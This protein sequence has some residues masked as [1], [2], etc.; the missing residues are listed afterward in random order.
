MW[1]KLEHPDLRLMMGEIVPLQLEL[2]RAK[3]W[4]VPVAFDTKEF[5][6]A[7]YCGVDPGQ[8]NS[9]L[10][11][12]TPLSGT[13]S[14]YQIECASS[15]DGVERIDQTVSVLRI[16]LQLSASPEY[17]VVEAAAHNALYGQSNLAEARTAAVAALMIERV[18]HI[19]LLPPKSVRK[20]AFGNGDQ[21]AE[22]LWPKLP[23]D[24]ASALACA[25]AARS[26]SKNEQ[27]TTA[28]SNHDAD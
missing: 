19:S 2:S 28:P 26:L 6:T 10:A 17:G 3:V 24:A 9:G 8:V 12:F 21:K 20:A 18:P 15:I 22:E 7:V 14:I 13:A 5:D 16:L 27:T 11:V 4:F 1:T 25:L 23:K